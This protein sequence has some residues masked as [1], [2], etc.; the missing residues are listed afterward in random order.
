[1]TVATADLTLARA[2]TAIA[3]GAL[4]PVD[5][6]VATL[7]RLARLEPRLNAFIT[8]CADEAM[9]QARAAEAAVASGSPLGPLHGVPISVKDNIDTLGIRTT[10]GSVFLIDQVP[11]ADATAVARLRA[12]GAIV[13]G[14]TNMHEFALGDTSINPHFGAVRNPWDLERIPGGSTGGGAAAVAA[15][16]GPATLGTDAGGSIRGPAA[17]CGV[18]GL[19]PTHGLVP[20]RGLLLAAT[21]TY[22]QMCPLTTT[23]ADA[24]LMLSIIAGHE[25]DDPT[26]RQIPIPDYRAVIDGEIGAA[27]IGVPRDLIGSVVDP[28]VATA[29]EEA[30]RVLRS[31]GASVEDVEIPDLELLMSARGGA[32][33]EGLPFH[34]TWMRE[35]LMEYGPDVRTQLLSAQFVLGKDYSLAMKARRLVKERFAAIFTRVD[36]LATPANLFPAGRIADDGVPV[37]DG[38]RIP[39]AVVGRTLAPANSAGIPAISVPCGFTAGGLPIGLQL[40]TAPFDEPTLLRAAAAYERATPWHERRPPLAP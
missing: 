35:R 13:F 37:V 36:L 6:M 7:D 21:P 2:A 9:A 1:M 17:Y 16:V 28:E 20:L 25:P 33:A 12:A 26:S 5:L 4:S 38:R 24:A 19:K 11:T 34:A 10:G 22:S 27:R 15:G 8:V 31:L 14:K 39:L 32:S 40:L 23:V 18:V 29:F 3:E 30:L